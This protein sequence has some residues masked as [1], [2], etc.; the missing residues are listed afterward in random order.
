VSTAQDCAVVLKPRAPSV[1]RMLFKR[2]ALAVP[3][4]LLLASPCMAAAMDWKKMS[5]EQHDA[6]CRHNPNAEDCAAA[7]RPPPMTILPPPA[8]PRTNPDTTIVK[9]IREA[10]L[11]Y[12]SMF[13]DIIIVTMANIHGVNASPP[14]PPY[15]HPYDGPI[16]IIED[17]QNI[18]GGPWGWVEMPARSGA[19]CKIHL[20]P[21]G[22][23]IDDA[24]G[25]GIELLEAVG[26]E[27]LL[28]HEVGHCHRLVHRIRADGT[29]DHSSWIPAP[30]TPDQRP[31]TA[32]PRHGIAPH[33]TPGS[34][35]PPSW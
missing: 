25:G 3:L 13:A 8:A 31:K 27:R 14:P 2:I 28:R 10:A 5:R 24:D 35:W 18:E 23:A 16:E 30:A 19:K 29:V 15:D 17:L 34:T 32:Q 20:A 7:E 33:A 1:K 6:F 26:R 12:R 11:R 22:S 4:T 21:I 9:A